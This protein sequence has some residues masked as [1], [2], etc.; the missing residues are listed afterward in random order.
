MAAHAQQGSGAAAQGLQGPAAATQYRQSKQI[1]Q[2]RRGGWRRSWPGHQAAMRRR[3]ER[4]QGPEA[5]A[6][7]LQGLEEAAEPGQEHLG[8]G[9]HAWEERGWC[10]REGRE[11]GRH[12]ARDHSR[13]R[14]RKVDIAGDE[15]RGVG[16][17]STGGVGVQGGLVRGMGGLVRGTDGTGVHYWNRVGLWDCGTGDWDG[18]MGYRGIGYWW[19]WGTGYGDGGTGDRDGRGG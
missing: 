11:A 9:T 17:L 5:A 19:D 4:R 6:H 3:R 8:T 16:L 18:G 12:G 1:R 15:G 13:N 2:G 7:W 14:T 10:W